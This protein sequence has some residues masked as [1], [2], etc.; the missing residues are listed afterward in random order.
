MQ[1]TESMERGQ[2]TM[3][4][5]TS[6]AIESLLNIHPERSWPKAPYLE[7]DQ[8]WVNAK[9]LLRNILSSFPKEIDPYLVPG[10]LAELMHDEWDNIRHTLS[11]TTK[12]EPVLYVSNYADIERRYRSDITP[13]R[14]DSTEKQKAAKERNDKALAIAMKTWTSDDIKIF[15]TDVTGDLGIRAIMLTH[16]PYDLIHYRTFGELDLLESHTG[17]VKNR[18]LW[19]TKFLNGKDLAVIPFT[20]YFLR[21]FGDKE[22]FSPMDIKLRRAL[23]ELG[24]KYNWTAL[25]TDSRVRMCVSFMKNP[26]FEALIRDLMAKH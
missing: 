7:Y 11:E 22:M 16:I 4:I 1:L 21:I 5:A 18:S 20:I 24:T 19:Y 15:T 10:Y 26:Y 17:M 14:R 2:L 25:T 12:L 23:V 9:T 13:I 6:L 8:I 3:N